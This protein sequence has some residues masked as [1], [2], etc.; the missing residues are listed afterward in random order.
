MKWLALALTLFVVQ[1]QPGI[2]VTPTSGE[3]GGEIVVSGSG[4]PAGERVKVLWDGA[5]LGGT[6]RVGPAGSFE[7]SGVVPDS[8]PGGHLVE[9]VAVGGGTVSATATFTVVTGATTTS[10]TSTSTSTTTA[11]TPTTPTSSPTTAASSPQT[12]EPASAP[13][14]V[15]TSTPTS[16]PPAAPPSTAAEIGGGLGTPTTSVGAERAPGTTPARVAAD[17]PGEEAA[18]STGGGLF[19]GV[20]MVMVAG[21]AIAFL[22]AGR[23]RSGGRSPARTSS[24]PLPPAEE[25]EPEE[26][27]PLD[28]SQVAGRENGWHRQLLELAPAG[29]LAGM[30]SSGDRLFGWGHGVDGGSEVARVWTSTD[31]L[32]W[33]GGDDLGAARALNAVGWRDGLLV[34]GVTGDEARVATRCWWSADGTRWEELIGAGDESLSGVVLGGV[35]VGHGTLVGWGRGPEGPGLWGSHD[36]RSW[37]PSG[38]TG[39]Y[40]LVAPTQ[41]GF[42][43]FG[44]DP[45]HRRSIVARSS[46]GEAWIGSGDE[47]RFLFDGATVAALVAVDGGMVAA[48]TDIMRGMAAL[49]VSD[50][51]AAWHRVPLD[52]A[53]GTSIESLVAIGDR[54]VAVGA[55]ASRRQAGRGIAVVWESSDVVSWRRV[56]AGDLFRSASIDSIAVA[57]GSLVATGTLFVERGGGRSEPVPAG[58]TWSP[59]PAPSTEEPVE[60]LA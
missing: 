28:P 12:A 50:D 57:D 5:N 39:V 15:A 20:L 60:A 59:A 1:V 33:L 40:D 52:E 51:G 48:G 27:R 7:Y 24:Q 11:P 18:P 25:P 10:T 21:A 38:I 46:D 23:S 35:T 13:A 55:D 47:A 3:T 43:A 30:V 22:L 31:A 4:F 42:V 54:L 19:L 56:D 29:D 6:V 16:A 53:I 36:G 26:L 45:E 44:R 32:H 9:A 8:A 17:G 14:P 34:A 2:S 49:W 37:Y 58:W 41:T